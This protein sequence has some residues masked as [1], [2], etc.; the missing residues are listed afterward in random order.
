MATL[1]DLL[2]VSSDLLYDTASMF[3]IEAASI[4]F[5]VITGFTSNDPN[6]Y[7]VLG[8]NDG[9]SVENT[10]LPTPAPALS[11]LMGTPLTLVPQLLFFSQSTQTVHIG[12]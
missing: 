11:R 1:L 3:S 9:T 2:I 5:D 10:A 6:G 8:N 12:I 4:D 7:I